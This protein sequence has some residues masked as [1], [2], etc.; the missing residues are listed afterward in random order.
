MSNSAP[1]RI[2]GA[3]PIIA[4]A[5][6]FATMASPTWGQPPQPAPPSLFGVP[7]APAAL[8]VAE[9]AEPFDDLQGRLPAAVPCHDEYWI[10]SSRECP[11]R[12]KH[13]IPGCAFD[14]YR[15][16]CATGLCPEH[17]G[18][19]AAALQPG[20]PVCI[21]VHGSFVD[22]QSVQNEAH[23]IYHWIRAASP[24]QPLNV[25]FYTWPS[26]GA[27]MLVPHLGVALYGKRA[28]HNGFY[29]SQL[30]AEI[31]GHHPIC[32]VGHSHGAR[33]VVSAMHLMGGGAVRKTPLGY[34]ALRGR[35]LRAVLVAA[36]IDHHW[37][38]PGERYGCAL[39]SVECLLNLQN[40]KDVAMN[41]YPLRAPFSRRALGRT[42]FTPKDRA[43]IGWQGAKLA[44]L[45][46]TS[47][48]GP[49][50]MWPN[51]YQHPEIAWAMAPYVYFWE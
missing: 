10:V 29:L 46:T 30:I 21:V 2:I 3:V 17:P 45:D 38:N 33:M 25:V 6:C 42:D 15:H 7:A 26:A 39:N 20:A 18:N 51:Y 8:P 47:L 12:G 36:A 32:L 5:L 35:R 49:G 31:P 14:Y 44:T 43:Q 4:V 9:A 37:L 24:N 48:I 41:A 23:A 28:S 50:H 16:T 19:F 40:R 13:C 22:W 34:D 27:A 11:Q 1:Q